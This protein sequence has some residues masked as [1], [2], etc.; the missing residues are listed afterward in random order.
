MNLGDSG[1]AVAVFGEAVER[2]GD[3]DAPEVQQAGR[4]GVGTQGARAG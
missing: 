4:L 3:S 1:A 2:F